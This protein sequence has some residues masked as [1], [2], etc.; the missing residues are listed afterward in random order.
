MKGSPM[1]NKHKDQ[2]I[3]NRV[4]LAP[5]IVSIQLLKSFSFG[6]RLLDHVKQE[7]GFTLQ[8]QDN[9]ILVQFGSLQYRVPNQMCV[10]KYEA[11]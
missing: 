1:S 4:Q 11:Q 2:P 7:D 8:E 9:F 5:R 10:V 6:P 3:A